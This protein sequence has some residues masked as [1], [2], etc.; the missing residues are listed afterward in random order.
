[1]TFP[2][3]VTGVNCVFPSLEE[4]DSTGVMP[5]MVPRTDAIVWE[6]FDLKITKSVASFT[7]SGGDLPLSIDYGDL[8]IMQIPMRINE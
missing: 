4:N 5:Q 7:I 3:T 2:I 1:L 8:W 6:F